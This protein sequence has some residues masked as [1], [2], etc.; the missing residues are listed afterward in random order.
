MPWHRQT[1]GDRLVIQ[2]LLLQADLTD[3]HLL[4]DQFCF[5][6]CLFASI[7]NCVPP[8]LAVA[9]WQFAAVN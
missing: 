1:I 8:G 3:S 2:T 4:V 6:F 5:A 7:D 9:R